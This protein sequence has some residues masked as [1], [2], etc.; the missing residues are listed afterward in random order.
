[1]S[2]GRQPP[3]TRA[4]EPGGLEVQ[5]KRRS[6]PMERVWG[7]AVPIGACPPARGIGSPTAVGAACG[8]PLGDG[9]PQRPLRTSW[10][11]GESCP[12]GGSCLWSASGGQ[13]LPSVPADHLGGQGVLPGRRSL[14]M[15]HL[16][17]MAAPSV[18][19]STA[20]GM[21]SPTQ[22]A[23]AAY[24][25]PVGTAAPIGA[26]GP[27]WGTRSLAQEAVAD[28]GALAGV[29]SPKRP[30]V[31]SWGD[32]GSSL[33][34]GSRLWSA[35]G[36]RSSHRRGR[37]PSGDRESCPGGGRCLW[38]TCGGWQPPAA[39][40]RQLGGRGS[41]P[42]RHSLPMKNLRGMIAPIGAC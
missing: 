40:A 12:A 11:D 33:G 20:G 7:T 21:R 8:A 36:G 27:P 34:G 18:R 17:G 31:D 26:G 14:P 3:T 13:Q 23:I 24:R 30:G 32:G 4:N 35:C 38:S 29:S 2:G 19:G 6:L 41:L 39:P 10:G 25:E 37:T 15:E 5:P 16:R 9:S 28:Y 1:M 22:A 42:R